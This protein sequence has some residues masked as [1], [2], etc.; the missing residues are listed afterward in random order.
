M[1]TTSGARGLPTNGRN[2]S[3]GSGSD[4]TVRIVLHTVS[5]LSDNGLL[6]LLTGHF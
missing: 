1:N 4:P 3:T 6:I 2:Q 5:H